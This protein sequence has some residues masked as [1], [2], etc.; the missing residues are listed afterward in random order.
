MATYGE[1][2]VKSEAKTCLLLTLLILV[3][4]AH[5]VASHAAEL[6]VKIEASN[7]E[8]TGEEGGRT[9]LGGGNPPCE[10]GSGCLCQGAL[11]IDLAI[12]AVDRDDL[13]L[14][15]SLADFMGVNATVTPNATIM[16]DLSNSILPFFEPV[17]HFGG[18]FARAVLQ[19]F[20]I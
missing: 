19:S 16:I 6:A 18:A 8:T 13:T 12:A 9:P 2:S 4:H 10:E 14:W 11:L 5:C 20:Q 3:T 15:M 1:K 7:S 17:L